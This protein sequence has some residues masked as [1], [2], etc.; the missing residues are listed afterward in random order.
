MFPLSSS[1][2]KRNDTGIPLAFAYLLADCAALYRSASNAAILACLFA[3]PPTMHFSVHDVMLVISEFDSSSDVNG[4]GIRSPKS[5]I[6]TPASWKFT[7]GC[8]FNS[9]HSHLYQRLYNIVFVQSDET[10]FVSPRAKTAPVRHIAQTN[11]SVPRFSIIA[12]IGASISP[13]L[14]KSMIFFMIF[15]LIIII[16]NKF[17]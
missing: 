7:K 12:G 5:V 16:I 9:N 4:L 1:H 11:H 17:F 6:D 8:R 10:R 15:I 3:S 2:P 13:L 14:N